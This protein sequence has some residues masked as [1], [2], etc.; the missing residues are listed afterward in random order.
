MSYASF[1]IDSPLYEGVLARRVAAWVVDVIL[2]GIL[3]WIAWLGVVLLGIVTFGVGFI[4][5]AALPAFGFFYHVLF[6]AGPRS[7][8]PGQ[9]MMDLSVRRDADF[10]PPSLAQAVLFTGGLWL[11]LSFAF[12][13]LFLAPFTQRQRALHD[14][15][16]GVVVLRNRALT[17]RLPSWNM[18]V[19]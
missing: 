19:R 15:V 6:L 11:T 17:L 16:A 3:V 8:T 9:M 2:I 13:L 10:G 4:L 7:A 18:G 12:F 5:L 14:I 1:E